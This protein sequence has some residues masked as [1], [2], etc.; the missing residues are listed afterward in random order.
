MR[1]FPSKDM[2]LAFEVSKSLVQGVL[3]DFDILIS[4]FLLRQSGLLT[5][6][7]SLSLI[8]TVIDVTFKSLFRFFIPKNLQ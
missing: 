8:T 5:Q 4:S 6:Q 1:T 3:S 7:G 2:E